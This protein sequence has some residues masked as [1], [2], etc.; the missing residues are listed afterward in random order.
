MHTDASAAYTHAPLQV[1]QLERE[2]DSLVHQ[3]NELRDSNQRLNAE[4]KLLQ[5]KLCSPSAEDIEVAT[6]AMVDISKRSLPR[7]PDGAEP[8]MSS[9]VTVT[10]SRLK[11]ENALLND[12]NEILQAR[13]IHLMD[14]KVGLLDRLEQEEAIATKLALETETIGEY[15][16]LYQ[17][18]RKIISD[19]LAEKNE[20]IGRLQVEKATMASRI[21][22]L[23]DQLAQFGVAPLAPAVSSFPPEGTV[24]HNTVFDLDEAVHLPP[25]L[26]APTLSTPLEWYEDRNPS[27]SH[28]VVV[29]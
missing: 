6:Q 13:I 24:I 23:Q 10:I 1:Q 16:A 2:R 22:A 5:S 19:Q 17:Q 3:V 9:I 8:S 29:V 25:R 7:G 20:V 12:R 26:T 14:E 15:I 11:R 21:D 4:V 18:Q 28:R 27:A